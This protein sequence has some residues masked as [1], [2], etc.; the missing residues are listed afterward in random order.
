MKKNV[1]SLLFVI[2]SVFTVSAETIE[3]SIIWN[4]MQSSVVSPF[5]SSYSRGIDFVIDNKTSFQLS[6]ISI[7]IMSNNV[8]LGFLEIDNTI[9]SPNSSKTI[10]FSLTNR[11]QMPDK[12]P[13]VVFKYEYCG[14]IEVTEIYDNIVITGVNCIK[15]NEKY[16]D[17]Y[18]D[19]SGKIVKNPHKGKLYICNGKKTVFL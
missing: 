13:S 7:E 10:S 9:V 5:G 2:F 16:C 6:I 1:L 14:K 18:Y 12:L 19:L 17:T 4:G 8:S 3:C 11:I 15:N